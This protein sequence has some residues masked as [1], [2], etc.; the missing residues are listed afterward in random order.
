MFQASYDRLADKPQ[1][2]VDDTTSSYAIQ[3]GPGSGKTEVLALKTVRL[4]DQSIHAS[5]NVAVITYTDEMARSL[6]DRIQML[7]GSEYE[8]LYVG[9]VHGFCLEHVITPYATLLQLDLTLPFRITG[10]IESARLWREVTKGEY[11]IDIETVKHHRTRIIDRGSGDWSSSP[12]SSMCR[13]YEERLI[14]L[15]A[16]DFDGIALNA[17]WLIR[18]YPQLRSALESKFPWILVDEYQDLSRPFHE[19]MCLLLHTHIKLVVV[20]DAN[21]AIFAHSEDDPIES[22]RR[23]AEKVASDRV[24]GGKFDTSHRCPQNLLDT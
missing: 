6:R 24:L 23:R 14:S 5:Q 18:D 10:E 15:K 4:L 19:L 20:G 22:L 2:V 1:K 13:K 11:D 3:A 9:T 17:Y 21:Q 12:L 16:I 7:G 8:N